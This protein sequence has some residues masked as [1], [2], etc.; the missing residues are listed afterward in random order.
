MVDSLSFDCFSWPS[1]FA[2]E[3]AG[4]E[5]FLFNNYCDAD[6]SITYFLWVCLLVGTGVFPG[7]LS[8]SVSTFVF[9]FRLD[10]SFLFIFLYLAVILFFVQVSKNVLVIIPHDHWF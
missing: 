1:C 6:V 2:D 10:D 8:L 5:R 7:L 4:A 3:L 9:I